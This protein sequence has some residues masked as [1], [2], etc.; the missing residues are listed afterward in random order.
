MTGKR[1]HEFELLDK[2]GEGGMGVVYEAIDHNLGR[3]IA[4]KILPPERVANP[5]RKQ[6]F[7]QEAKAASALNHPNIVTIYTIDSAEGIDYIAMELVRGNKIG[8]AHV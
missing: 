2:L 1:L 3:H 8:R 5:T 6:R 7:I 4:L